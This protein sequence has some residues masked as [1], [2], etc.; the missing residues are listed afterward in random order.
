MICLTAIIRTRKG[1][2][3][4]MK[5]ALLDVLEYVKEHEIGTLG[6]FVSQSIE[7]PCIFTTYERF[8]DQKAMDIHNS[9]KKHDEFFEIATPLLD[10]KVVI[11]ICE[12]I[13]VK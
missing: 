1:K 11:Q 12:E 13:A 6:F 4:A 5:K 9:S 10:G 8:T 3:R 2:G 7:D